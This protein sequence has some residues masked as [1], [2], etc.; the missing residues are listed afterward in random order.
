MFQM[1]HHAETQGHDVKLFLYGNALIHTARN[2]ATGALRPDADFVLFMDDDML[3][4]DYALTRLVEH[5]LPAVS[6]LCTNRNP[7]VSLVAKVWDA[8]S[9]QFRRV[10]RINMEKVVS[11]EFAVGGAFLLLKRGV[12]DQLIEYHLSGQDWLDQNVEMLNIL[13]V[14]ATQRENYV[15]RLSEVRRMR[16]EADRYMLLWDFPVGIDGLMLGEDVSFCQKLHRLKVPVAI[17]GGLHIGHVAE[18]PFGL[19]D[20]LRQEREGI[21]GRE[22]DATIGGPVTILPSNVNVA[23]VQEVL[24]EYVEARAS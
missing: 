11:G 6:G 24:Q 1:I 14:R 23:N 18:Y 12:V 15:K 19:W 16:W 3:A 8:V 10:T 20:V 7:P 4:P 17:D 9:K 22:E 5:N 13:H 21:E 2:K